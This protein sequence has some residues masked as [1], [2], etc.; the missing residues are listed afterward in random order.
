[1]PSRLYSNSPNLGWIYDNLSVSE[2]YSSSLNERGNG[3]ITAGILNPM[4]GM[5]EGALGAQKYL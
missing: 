2:E 4:T 3:E 1:M 5:G